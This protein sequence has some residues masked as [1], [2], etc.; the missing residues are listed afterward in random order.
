MPMAV[1]VSEAR[2]GST[3]FLT[4][5][6]CCLA[7]V[8]EGFDL[9]APGVT[10]P[11][12]RGVFD[13]TPSETGYFL[14]MS[15]FGMMLGALIGGQ[16][17]DRIG[18]KW[19]LTGSVA[20]FGLFSLAT[21]FSTTAEMLYWTRF[22]TGLGLGGA[23]PNLVALSVESVP[24]ER[25]STAVGLMLA[26]PPIGGALA[27]LVAALAA[28]PEQWTWVYYAGGFVPLVCVVPFLALF[29]PRD[30]PMAR[31]ASSTNDMKAG[32]IHTLFSDGRASRT[33]AVWLGLFSILLV[34]FVLLGWLPTL[35]VDKGLSRS[36]ASLVQMVFNL[37]AIPGSILSGLTLDFALRRRMYS[38]LVA[39]F[40]AALGAIVLLA[41]GPVS[42]G[43]MLVAAA[44]AGLSV[45]G[46]Q[47][48]IYAL[49]PRC[50]PQSGRGTGMGFGVAIG[51]F[52]SAGGP[53]FT[54]YL[55]ALGLS[56]AQ[57]L[58]TLLP[59]GAVAGA[60][61]VFIAASLSSVGREAGAS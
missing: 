53:L 12:L 36:E 46:A 61:A 2:A 1:Q 5:A 52:G 35:M 57:V 42:A 18:R 28:T 4:V 7:A 20:T 13:L 44:C 31:S 45:I 15:T 11:V 56:S 55:V 51:R 40:V 59:I 22:A 17:S 49:A 34:L 29:L 58:M 23:L 37:S 39:A 33:L 26:G 41:Y 19:V 43:V 32:A 6:L 47:T 38:A 10:A 54:G 21:A 14:S 48:M 60:A 25:R 27:S 8:C 16:L 30:E 9:Q 24:A 3:S 50:Y